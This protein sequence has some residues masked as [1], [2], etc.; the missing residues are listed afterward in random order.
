MK[1]RE[2]SKE[3][4]HDDEKQHPLFS[5]TDHVRQLIVPCLTVIGMKK[6]RQLRMAGTKARN[7]KNQVDPRT[8]SAHAKGRD[9]SAVEVN[10]PDA[11]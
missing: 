1:L 2:V 7:N 6:A 8:G 5:H 4:I 9:S 3:I 10:Q 11:H